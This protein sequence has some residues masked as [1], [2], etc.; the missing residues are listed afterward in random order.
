MVLAAVVTV[1]LVALSAVPAPGV[2]G[3]VAG[4]ATASDPV[5][6][7]NLDAGQYPDP[8]GPA[9]P[10]WPMTVYLNMVPD[11][12][13][14][15][16]ALAISDPLSPTYGQHLDL[17]DAV[18]TFGAPADALQAVTDAVTGVGATV[19][20]GPSNTYAKV[21][22]T[23]GQA[24][25]L[26][27]VDFVVNEVVE[28]SQPS[29]ICES[30]GAGVL[31][32]SPAP[33][34]EP[35]LPGSLAGLI[36]AA[37]GFVFT[38]PSQ[39]APAVPP[40]AGPAGPGGPGPV[41]PDPVGPDPV[42]PDPVGPAGVPASDDAVQTPANWFRT[43]T[44]VGCEAGLASPDL[45]VDPSLGTDLFL[46]L[47]PNQLAT[48]YGYDTLAEAGLTGTGVRLAVLE[49]GGNVVPADL[50]A[51][52]ECF[53]YPAPALRQVNVPADLKLPPTGAWLEATLDAQVVAQ[54]APGLEAFDL[55]SYNGPSIGG[56][57][58]ILD[59]LAMPLDPAVFGQA[60][61][62]IV[63]VSYGWCEPAF[64]DSA[65][66]ILAMTEQL[67]ALAATTPMTYLVSSGDNGSSGCQNL[68]IPQLLSTQYPASSPW[69]LSVGGTSLDLN[70]DNTI[71]AEAVWNDALF[72]APVSDGAGGGGGGVSA[73][74]D[75]PAWQRGPG[76]EPGSKRLVPDVASFADTFPGWIVLCT[77]GC[78]EG[79]GFP[80]GYLNVGGTSASTPQVAAILALITEGTRATGQPP[81]GFVAPLVY[82]LAR[83]GSDALRDVTVTNNDV[84]GIGCCDATEGHDL[85][86]GW[87]SVNA[88]ALAMALADPTVVLTAQ[89]P[90]PASPSVVL[91][92]S[93]STAPVG[94]IVD[95]GWDTTGD[96]VIDIVTT[97]P[98]VT[99]PVSL[100]NPWEFSVTAR[101]V[102]GRSA[103]ASVTVLNPTPAP[104]PGPQPATPAVV[105]P[106]FT[107]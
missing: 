68:G 36:D 84:N 66:G 26:F 58:W 83:A 73:E 65:T 24:A 43:G 39:A 78:A 82:E 49:E 46:G 5:D 45:V 94:A 53:G 79:G 56:L 6:W 8:A 71:N 63:S 55:Y 44:A 30:D 98:T 90:T 101:T 59:M 96:G 51:H 105:V 1:A 74:F 88:T 16:T 35:S 4:A 100:P 27:S 103:M 15:P 14:V 12:D 32:V 57:S 91:D 23:V 19:E 37:F 86:S 62:D 60:P 81:L 89:G 11:P 87:G 70:D 20:F 92:A 3:V 40:G 106:R 48:A 31:C 80:A 52:A 77:G 7:S 104:R 50:V 25:E 76:V 85:A 29:L 75:R 28:Q 93:G 10:S 18:S 2:A 42:G 61:P 102:T 33:G 99:V 21:Q 34:A 69:V 72:P 47:A 13:L 41:G 22:L 54:I 17:F 97:E 64:T 9:D 95:Y 107:G 38:L 67:L